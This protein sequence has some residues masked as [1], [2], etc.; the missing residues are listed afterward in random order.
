MWRLFFPP[1]YIIGEPRQPQPDL[2]HQGDYEQHDDPAE[3]NADTSRKM[4][5]SDVLV[6]EAAFVE[7]SDLL[8]AL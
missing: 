4:W 8:L 6:R 1:A 3:D 7:I 2:G 5:A